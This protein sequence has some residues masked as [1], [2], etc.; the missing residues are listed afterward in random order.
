M[1][2]K[3]KTLEIITIEA[4]IEALKRNGWNRT[5]TAHELE[6]AVRTVGNLIKRAK[7]LGYKIEQNEQHQ[8]QMRGFDSS[9]FVR[10]YSRRE[11]NC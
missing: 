5:K 8:Q 10:R 4:L 7:K 3:Q 1:S 9:D 6:I 11:P 2:E